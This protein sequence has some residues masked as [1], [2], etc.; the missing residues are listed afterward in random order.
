[1]KGVDVAG[2][3]SKSGAIAWLL[4]GLTILVPNTDI[5]NGV[6]FGFPNVEYK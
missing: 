1:M 3:F 2:G 5:V 4:V 6:V